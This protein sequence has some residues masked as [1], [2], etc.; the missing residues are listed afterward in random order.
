MINIGVK[1][2]L[3]ENWK[4][5]A[6]ID[7]DVDFESNTWATDTLKLLNGTKDIVQL[8]SHAIDMDAQLAT[9]NVAN[10]FAFQ[11][12][13]GLPYTWKPPNYWHP[14]YAWAI[15]RKAYEF[16]GGVFEKSILGAGDH[17]MT[18]CLTNKGLMA[19]DPK[20]SDDLKNEVVKFQEKARHL[21]LG[22]VPGVIRHF[23]HGSKANRKYVER[24]Q[25]LLKNNFQPNVQL[26]KDEN[27]ILIPN[28]NFSQEF[29][30]DIYEY[31]SQ[32]NEDEE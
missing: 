2:L 23:Y 16:I 6:W 7:A 32:R 19:I 12:C 21:R 25:I 22:Y 29:I 1:K 30:N 13:K 5:M 24:N 11:Y 9:M 26:S 4:A 18:F 31:F 3:P 17:I 27:G 15:T 20:Y 10:S 28:E 14:G 8:F